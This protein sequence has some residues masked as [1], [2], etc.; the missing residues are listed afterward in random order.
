MLD[1]GS[2]DRHEWDSV[3][4]DLT[5]RKLT[6]LECESLQTVPDNYTNHVIKHTKI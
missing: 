2:C 3:K 6:P 4:D 1:R 5:W